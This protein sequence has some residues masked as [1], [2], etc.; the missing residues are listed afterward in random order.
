M[1]SIKLKGL[2]KEP[3]SYKFSE[4]F[5]ETHVLGYA[6]YLATYGQKENQYDFELQLKASKFLI[7]LIK[8][9]I[10]DCDDKLIDES[11]DLGVYLTLDDHRVLYSKCLKSLKDRDLLTDSEIPEL[12]EVIKESK[13]AQIKA[14]K[15]KLSELED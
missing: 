7:Q 6:S 15:D 3:K 12:N 5:V 14:L 13:E 4:K 2:N 1:G 8:I 10:P 9:F 11:V